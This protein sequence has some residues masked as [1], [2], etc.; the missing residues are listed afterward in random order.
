MLGNGVRRHTSYGLEQ[1]G[2][3]MDVQVMSLDN[4]DPTIA[5]PDNEIANTEF[6]N[7][8]EGPRTRRG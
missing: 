5:L 4:F 7:S 1:S 3:S 6:A 2:L 8:T